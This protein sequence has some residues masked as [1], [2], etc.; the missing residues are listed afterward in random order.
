MVIIKKVTTVEPVYCVPGKA[1]SKKVQQVVV[2]A[3]N[4]K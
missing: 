1:T 2:E 3:Q 4:E